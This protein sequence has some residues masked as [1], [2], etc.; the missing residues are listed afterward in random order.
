MKR[1]DFIAHCPF[2][3]D[4]K[5]KIILDKDKN[6]LLD[7]M[8]TVRDITTIHSLITGEVKF[9]IVVKYYMDRDLAERNIC[10][11]QMVK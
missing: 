5:V 3:M 2:E 4:D 6:I 8:Y 1:T 7:S 11:F 10:D 9:K